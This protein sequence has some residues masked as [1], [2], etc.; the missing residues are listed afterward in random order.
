MGFSL[1]LGSI[2]VHLRADSSKLEKSLKK[3]EKVM[4][5]AS[6]KM[7]AIGKKMTLSLTAPIVAMGV[8][9]VRSFAKFDD[10]M[11][12]STAI[13]GNMTDQ[14]R[15]K[16]EQTARS[17]SRKGVTSAEELARSYFFLWQSSSLK[18]VS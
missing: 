5:R 1:D 11:T 14:M 8:L 16:M 6:K 2:W 9:A 18:P 3:A 7:T 4:T 10:A 15:D 12:K 13:M 17:I